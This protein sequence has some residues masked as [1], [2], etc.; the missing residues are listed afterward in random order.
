MPVQRRGRI[1]LVV[2]P[3]PAR[4]D[5]WPVRF[6]VPF[7]WGALASDKNVRITNEDGRELPI[8]VMT[9]GTWSKGG[10]V[11]WLLV[12]AQVPMSQQKKTLWLEFGPGVTRQ[13]GVSMVAETDGQITVDTGALRFSVPRKDTTGLGN[14][15]QQ[16]FA[17]EGKVLDFKV[18]E[19]VLQHVKTDSE[20]YNWPSAKVVNAIGLAKSH[21]MLLYFHTHDWEQARSREINRIFQSAPAAMVDPAW[22]CRTK[23]L[24]HM[25]PKDAKK[26][27]EA[28]TAVDETIANIERL[29][30]TDRDYG[31]FNYGD[32]HHNWDWLRRRWNLHRIWRN[33][34]HGWTRWPWMMYARWS[35]PN[36]RLLNV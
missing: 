23:A 11:R 15:Y 31:M 16:W 7:P 17:H 35:R 18:P 4:A 26:F 36:R 14:V 6:G 28:E 25:F 10:S 24:G 1:P 33:T 30:R 27:A 20:K 9:A 5:K 2:T 21:E 8:Q 3:A 12:D 19:E 13:A 29:R 34:H 22:V 32:S